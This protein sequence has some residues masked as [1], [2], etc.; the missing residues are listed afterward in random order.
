[1]NNRHQEVNSSNS[2][3]FK[4]NHHHHQNQ[5]HKSNYQHY[6]PN[7]LQ[8]QHQLQLQQKH[9]H[10]HQQQQQHH[11]HDTIRLDQERQYQTSNQA[12][13]SISFLPLSPTLPGSPSLSAAICNSTNSQIQSN[14]NSIQL[15]PINTLN[16]INSP[17]PSIN[18]FHLITNTI[19]QSNSSTSTSTINPTTTTTATT[20]ATAITSTDNPIGIS[21]IHPISFNTGFHHITLPNQM[22][23]YYHHHHHHHHHHHNNNNPFYNQQS[24]KHSKSH[25]FNQHHPQS[26]IQSPNPNQLDHSSS[27]N[28]HLDHQAHMKPT[29]STSCS[30]IS[31]AS[32]PTISTCYEIHHPEPQWIT[33]HHQHHPNSPINQSQHQSNLNHSNCK[34]RSSPTS[35]ATSNSSHPL[36]SPTT[37]IETSSSNNPSPWTPEHTKSATSPHSHHVNHYQ[38]LSSLNKSSSD[39]RSQHLPSQLMDYQKISP[40]HHLPSDLQSQHQLEPSNISHSRSNQTA[41]QPSQS[42]PRSHLPTTSAPSRIESIPF[43][44]KHIPTSPPISED[45]PRSV[46]RKGAQFGLS[47]SDFEVICT[48][49]TGTFGK[50]LLVRLRSQHNQFYAM[51][52]LSKVEIVRLKQVEHMNSEKDLLALVSSQSDAKFCVSL[53]CTFQD[54]RNLYMMLEF[55]QGG[56]LFSHLRR[57]GRFTSDVA[58]F[59]AANVLLALQGLHE[60]DIVYRDLKPENILLGPNGYI[61]LTDFGFAKKVPDRTWTLCGTPEYLAPEIIQSKGHGKP[62]DWWAFGVLLYEMLSGF[63]PFFCSDGSGPFGIYEKILS[64]EL[65]F[66]SHIDPLAQDLISRL[67]TSD[68]S[69]RLG[70]LKGGGFDVRDHPW[71]AGVDWDALSRQTIR[72]PILPRIG[73]P[74]DSSNFEKY[75]EVRLEDLPGMM[76]SHGTQVNPSVSDPYGHLFESF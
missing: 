45:R 47:L 6:Q 4:V 76:R 66:P 7:Q 15:P 39:D 72:A 75:P 62:A 36:L 18:S 28:P 64:G 61:K 46:Y 50:V 22:S 43:I 38:H 53:N 31:L 30:T 67:L 35:S 57:A 29:T 9:R 44:P 10:H 3:D 58:R 48:L 5:N 71:F 49:G 16:L 24:L 54:E 41:L 40:L 65:G 26:L 59:F 51:K 42:A 34:N 74:G 2:L 37:T 25:S 73:V 19:P 56:E 32:S 69:K 1:M 12:H 60:L 27:S 63:P 17:T 20:T 70:N 13:H 23:A 68:R 11:H 33:F 14:L 55:V 52:V 21:S 8:L